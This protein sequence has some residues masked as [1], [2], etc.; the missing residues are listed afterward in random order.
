MRFGAVRFKCIETNKRALRQRIETNSVL[1]Y[2]EEVHH[3]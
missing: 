1:P 3:K 2:Y